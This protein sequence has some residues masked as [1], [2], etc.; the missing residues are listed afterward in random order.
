MN[1]A[2]NVARPAIALAAL[3]IAAAWTFVE[4][5]YYPLWSD[6]ADTAIF[7]RGV[8]ETGDTSAVVGPNIYAYRN[9][10]LLE[11]LKNRYTPPASYYLT[12]PFYG[13]FGYDTFWLRFPFALCGLLGVAWIVAWLH[14]DQARTSTWLVT[15]VVL[16]GSVPYFLY[17]RQCRYY[18]LAMLTSLVVVR[19]YVRWQASGWRECV[20]LM[21]SLVLL[22]TQYMNYVAL[23]AAL[24]VDYIGWQR[25]TQPLGRR[26]LLAILAPQLCAAGLLLAVYNPLGKPG[27]DVPVARGF[28]ANK[29]ILLIWTLRDLNNC[30]YIPLVVVATAAIVAFLRRDAW[31]GRG[32]VGLVVYVVALTLVSP[33][34]TTMTNVADVRY[35]APILPLG[36]WI[37]VRTLQDLFPNR[38]SLAVGWAVIAGWTT[39]FYH[40]LTPALWRSTPQAFARELLE[41]RPTAMGQVCEWF[42][43]HAKDGESVFVLPDYDTYPLMVHLPKLIYG[44]Q[45]PRTRSLLPALPPIHYALRE[46]VDYIVTFGQKN[47]ELAKIAER[48]KRKQVEYRELTRIDLFW[49]DAT[50]PELCW[51]RFEPMRQF[52]KTKDAVWI[53]GRKS[54]G[55]RRPEALG[56]SDR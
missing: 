6:E 48:M 43:T 41:R 50:R 32:I 13:A 19:C 56:M 16:L 1:T 5:G 39:I 28:V 2:R 10:V 20:L 26:T 21:A 30:E 42:A 44:W 25:H 24:V 9:G 12:A 23:Y 7:A 17:V 45:F 27:F 35:L 40:P 36:A 52:D 29:L 54:A 11:G 33:Q 8:W 47:H 3:T 4:L 18:A 37:V 51:H 46:P 55:E 31:L 49:D 38:P 14:E 34:E 22:A 15:L 53:Y